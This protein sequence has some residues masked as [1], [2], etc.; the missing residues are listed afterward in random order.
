MPIDASWFVVTIPRKEH[1]KS[2][3]TYNLKAAELEDV[4][5]QTYIKNNVGKFC[6]RR[7]WISE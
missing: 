1:E 3:L 5:E 7:S 6:F 4:R 2:I